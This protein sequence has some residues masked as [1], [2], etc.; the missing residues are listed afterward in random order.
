MARVAPAS[1]V[2]LVQARLIIVDEYAGRD[3]HGVA[4]KQPF[5]NAALTDDLLDLARDVDKVHPGRHVECQ[6]LGMRFHA[7]NTVVKTGIGQNWGQTLFFVLSSNWG[8]TWVKRCSLNINFHKLKFQTGV[9]RC[10]LFFLWMDVD[11]D[12]S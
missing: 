8:Q 1:V 4:Q 12:V 11:H 10:S 3:V 2:I 6:V 9:K 5:L 7:G